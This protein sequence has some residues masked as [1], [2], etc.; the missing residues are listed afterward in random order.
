MEYEAIM[1]RLRIAQALGVKT[2]LLRSDSQLI[3]VKGNFEAK[4]TRM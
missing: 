4:E 2:T 3:I 1:T